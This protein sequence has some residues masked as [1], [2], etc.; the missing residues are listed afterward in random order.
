M[1]IT[2]INSRIDNPEAAHAFVHEIARRKEETSA[3]S[4]PLAL[5]DYWLTWLVAAVALFALFN[6]WRNK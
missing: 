2:L 1:P 3:A 5:L 6:F 4:G